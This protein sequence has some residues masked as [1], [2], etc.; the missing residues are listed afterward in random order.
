MEPME[1]ERQKN[2]GEAKHKK[3]RG[4]Q[5]IVSFNCFKIIVREA[6]CARENISFR[7]KF[8]HSSSTQN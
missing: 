1:A 8:P 2:L 5:L 6:I 4:Y 3:F 7:T